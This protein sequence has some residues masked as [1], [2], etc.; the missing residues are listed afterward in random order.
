VYSIPKRAKAANK[1][2]P[3]GGRASSGAFCKRTDLRFSR[4]YMAVVVEETAPLQ[5]HGSF[6]QCT[7]AKVIY[8]IF[9]TCFAV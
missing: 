5:R 6:S 7:T 4:F 2:V 1:V 8:F 9:T 3:E